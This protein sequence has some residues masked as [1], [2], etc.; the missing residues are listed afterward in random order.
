MLYLQSYQKSGV[1]I[2]GGALKLESRKEWS[3][4]GSPYISGKIVSRADRLLLMNTTLT[5]TIFS[6]ISTSDTTITVTICADCI[7]HNQY[8][9]CY[10]SDCHY[11]TSYACCCTLY[12]DTSTCVCRHLWICA[13]LRTAQ[14]WPATIAC[15]AHTLRCALTLACPMLLTTITAV[16][17]GTTV[18][19]M[20]GSKCA[21]TSHQDRGCGQ[22]SGCCQ[23]TMALMASTA[24][25]LPL[26]RLT[27]LR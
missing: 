6:I 9:C 18:H 16:T 10:H 14:C 25:G 15:T 20:A 8:Y 1:S 12:W 26:E 11:N 3:A 4:D 24:T 22:L 13:L 7:Q 23:I 27:S 19:S 21:P 2:V 5:I 17:A